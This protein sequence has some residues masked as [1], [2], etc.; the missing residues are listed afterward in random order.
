[1]SDRMKVFSE[2]EHTEHLKLLFPLSEVRPNKNNTKSIENKLSQLTDHRTIHK[3][4]LLVQKLQ[5]VCWRW[6]KNFV[7]IFMYQQQ[8]KMLTIYQ[9]NQIPKTKPNERRAWPL[10]REL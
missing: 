1:M 9:K 4:K 2:I 8:K 10:Q 6:G 7:C 3:S 5:Q